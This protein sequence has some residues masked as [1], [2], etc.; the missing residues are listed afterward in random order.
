MHEQYRRSDFCREADYRELEPQRFF[1]DSLQPNN[2][3]VAMILIAKGSE[4]AIRLNTRI[5]EIAR[6]CGKSLLSVELLD[7]DFSIEMKADIF[8]ENGYFTNIHDV[9][10]VVIPELG[11]VMPTEAGYLIPYD[12][13]MI[14]FNK[15]HN[16]SLHLDFAST[17]M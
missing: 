15:T 10:S 17:L 4:E 6:N 7:S 9:V 12:D 11:E 16:Q 13:P 8:C 5:T 2:I 14:D 1:E 3:Y